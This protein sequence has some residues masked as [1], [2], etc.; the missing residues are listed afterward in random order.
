MA[1]TYGTITAFDG[2][3]KRVYANGVNHLIPKEDWLLT[4]LEFAAEKKLGDRYEQMVVLSH[5]QGFTGGGETGD[6]YALNDAVTG[7]T[8]PAYVKGSEST[9]RGLLSKAAIER[10]SGS[11]AAFTRGT[12]LK[13]QMMTEAHAK[14]ME[15]HALYGQSDTGLGTITSISGTSTTRAFVML[16]QHWNP[17]IWSGMKNAR[18]DAYVSTSKQNSNA[19]IVVVSVD[20]T[21]RTVNVSGNAT[22]LTALDTAVSGN[23]TYLVR[24]GF[25]DKAFVG[26]DKI[27][28]TS[29]GNLFGLAVTNELWKASTYDVG[30]SITSASDLTMEHCLNALDQ[31]FERGGEGDRVL[32]CA[33]RAFT[34][35][36]LDEAALRRFGAERKAVNGF[37]T[38]EFIGSSGTVKIRP[39]RYC[40]WGEA[41][42]I[43]TESLKWVGAYKG[44]KF[45]DAFG[46]QVFWPVSG[47]NGYEM[48][49][50]S[51]SALFCDKPG[52]IVKLRYI[53]S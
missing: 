5:E 11:E 36:A 33:N 18:L 39:H 3:F 50:Y 32:L 24:K 35:L 34:D 29:S 53:G 6:A 38:I 44:V 20:L 27:S 31:S 40:K 13:I 25:Y 47:Y 7:E 46:G 51:D 22:D 21:T 9:L 19:D 4:E 43:P 17:G 23:D 37:D 16:Q 49:S 42:V 10:S 14:L 26:I 12:K 41:Y 2:N 8:A 15:V 1:D 28:T 45:E 30:S 48:R 52:H